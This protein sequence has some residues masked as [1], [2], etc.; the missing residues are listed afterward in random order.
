MVMVE[1]IFLRTF[2]GEVESVARRREFYSTKH[3][4]EVAA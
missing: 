3:S 2:M 1:S 4:S